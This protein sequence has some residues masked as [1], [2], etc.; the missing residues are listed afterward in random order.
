LTRWRP[1]GS[2]AGSLQGIAI[3]LIKTAKKSGE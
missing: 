2:S 3:A 1:F